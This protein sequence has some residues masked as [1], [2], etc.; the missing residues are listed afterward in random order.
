MTLN[1]TKIDFHPEV[2]DLVDYYYGQFYKDL[3]LEKLYERINS[4][5]NLSEMSSYDK[6]VIECATRI[7]D[8][9]VSGKLY[10]TLN[11]ADVIDSGNIYL[12]RHYIKLAYRKL[13]EAPTNFSFWNKFA[14]DVLASSDTKLKSAIA[15]SII[16]SSGTGN[17]FNLEPEVI[18]GFQDFINYSKP[19]KPTTSLIS[20]KSCKISPLKLKRAQWREFKDLLSSALKIDVNSP[21]KF[22][23]R[24][25]IG[26]FEII[27]F[28][29]EYVSLEINYRDI[30]IAIFDLDEDVDLMEVENLIDEIDERVI[31]PWTSCGSLIRIDKF[32]EDLIKTLPENHAG[33][34][35]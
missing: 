8:Y 29:S 21:S 15:S 18:N 30:T 16:W 35:K 32:Y 19:V 7:C 13:Q 3:D 26:E 34:E 17:I 24:T 1:T 31:M 22:C 12:L 20:L 14:K 5:R 25:V 23:D 28:N 2:A 27:T 33:I 10:H 11:E 9:G 6:T 4:I